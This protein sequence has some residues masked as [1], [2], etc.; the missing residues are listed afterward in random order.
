MMQTTRNRI[1]KLERRIS[2][3]S[4]G[5]YIVVTGCPTE[6]DVSDL[7]RENGIDAD[8][9]ANTV[10]NLKRFIV[11]RDGTES[12]FQQKPEILSARDLK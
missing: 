5:K 6:A 8:N 4:P 11:A 9:P 1:S 3:P 10:I 2:P 12:L 7:L